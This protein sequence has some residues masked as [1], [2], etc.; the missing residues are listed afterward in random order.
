[1]LV[2]GKIDRVGTADAGAIEAA[3]FDLEVVDA[4]GCV[5]VP[6]FIDPHEHLL[7]GSG[8]G[9]FA[10]QS[11]EIWINEIVSWGITTVVGCLGVDTTMKTLP[12]LLA[13]VKMLR[14]EGLSA[15]MWTGGY[16]VPPTT[17]TDSVR[18]DVLF[19][20]EII[21][22]G[23]IAIADERATEPGP[24]ELARVVH[25]AYVGGLLSGKAGVTHF[26]VGS[27]ERRLACLREILDKGRF[28]IEP[29]WLY[30]THVQ[31]NEQL[32]D[33]AL[34]LVRQGVTVDFD[35][36]EADLDRW[37]PYY[38]EHGGDPGRLTI[39]SDAS[40]TRPGQLYDQ[41]CHVVVH[42]R[43]PLELVLPMLTS[44]TARMLKLGRKGSLYRGNEGDV[45]V[46]RRG[47]LEIV[48]VIA[49]GKTMVRDGELVRREHFLEKSN[50]KV[51]LHGTKD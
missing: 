33:E 50:R 19:V 21:G 48:H 35:V 37:L 8:E 1:L 41:F 27:G 16:N 20:E 44:N 32:L 39:S 6:G 17:F 5:V 24:A 3:G 31:R 11:P 22:A 34:E 7:G 10:L 14:E 30:P 45:V 9:G 38:L 4:S 23:E 25:D 43:M 26:H 12:G 29:S 36:A 28:Q 51:E 15:Y 42:R 40:L 2:D 49:G 47:S 18:N 13:K 46:L